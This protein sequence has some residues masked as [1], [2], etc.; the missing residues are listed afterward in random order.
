MAGWNERGRRKEKERRG[1]GMREAGASGNS[2]P[3]SQGPSLRCLGSRFPVRAPAP[4]RPSRW[5]S[6]PILP[7]P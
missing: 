7:P 6:L 2:N 1:E 5:K 3:F 4:P